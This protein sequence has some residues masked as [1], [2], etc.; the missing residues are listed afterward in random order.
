MK[1][2]VSENDFAYPEEVYK[3]RKDSNS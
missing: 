1:K 2:T 3:H